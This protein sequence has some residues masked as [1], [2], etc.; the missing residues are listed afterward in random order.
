MGTHNNAVLPTF[1]HPSNDRGTPDPAPG[2]HFESKDGESDS[3]VDALRGRTDYLSDT[4]CPRQ[5]SRPPNALAES[6]NWET[7]PVWILGM[8]NPSS[9]EVLGGTGILDAALGTYPPY[10]VGPTLLHHLPFLISTLGSALWPGPT[11]YRPRTRI[12][13]HEPTH[14]F[15]SRSTDGQQAGKYRPVR[16]LR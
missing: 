7:I 12:S 5:D 10:S 13:D 16:S 11:A 4:H 6:V 15:L 14:T 3:E 2:V 8:A 9:Q 1:H